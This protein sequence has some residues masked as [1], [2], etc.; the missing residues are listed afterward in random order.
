MFMVPSDCF[1]ACDL[2]TWLFKQDP[3]EKIVQAPEMFPLPF[4]SVNS[5]RSLCPPHPLPCQFS[6]QAYVCLFGWRDG[7]QN[8]SL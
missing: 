5:S 2:E 8:L 7:A 1:Q 3:F 4:S 6:Q